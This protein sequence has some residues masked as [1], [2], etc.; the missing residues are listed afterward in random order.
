MVGLGRRGPHGDDVES[1]RF[2]PDVRLNYAE[3]LL[4][5]LPDAGDT[6]RP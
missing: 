4:R 6:T 5:P 3:A 1:A 2:F